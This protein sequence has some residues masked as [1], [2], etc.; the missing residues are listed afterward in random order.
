MYKCAK[1]ATPVIVIGEEKIRACKCKKEDG[2]PA[3]I[4]M[5]MSA[6]TKGHGG[7]KG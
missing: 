3:S 5:E 7:V 1:C 6:V 2:T 4:V